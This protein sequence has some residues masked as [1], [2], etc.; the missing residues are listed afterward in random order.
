METATDAAEPRWLNPAERAAWLGLA[1]V[2]R[3]LPAAL[4]AQLMADSGLHYSEYLVLAMLSDQPD[5]R[6]RMSELASVLYTSQ[7][8]LSYLAKRLE[9]MEYLRR[10]ADP[11]DRRGVYA[12]ATAAGIAKVAEAAP[13]HVAEVRRIVLDGLSSAQLGQMQKVN[14]R[15]L[16]RIGSGIVG[17]PYSPENR[18]RRS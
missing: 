13:G 5:H 9:K 16:A 14:E 15:V 11:A 2:I 4:D 10:E 1:G 18:A 3:R 12:V 8:L 17:D 7:S 6:L